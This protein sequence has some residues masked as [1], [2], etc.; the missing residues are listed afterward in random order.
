M[1]ATLVLLLIGLREFAGGIDGALLD[2]RCECSGVCQ[3]RGEVSRVQDAWLD[4]LDHGTALLHGPG[5][6][7]EAPS[8]SLVAAL[9]WP[10]GL[11]EFTDSLGSG[12]ARDARRTGDDARSLP[13]DRA[14]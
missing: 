5:F 1:A 8:R 3:A 9:R 11:P 10:G 12:D 14:L 7:L 4:L 6:H 2:L 13:N